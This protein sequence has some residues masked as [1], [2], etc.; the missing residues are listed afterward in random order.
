MEHDDALFYAVACA[1][2]HSVLIS[3]DGTCGVAIGEMD[4]AYGVVHLVEVFLVLVV[5]RH[6]FELAYHLL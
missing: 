1:L 6:G 3:P 5:A 4:I 2:L